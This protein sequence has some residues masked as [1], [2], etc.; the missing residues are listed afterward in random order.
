MG[1][2]VSA[3]KPANDVDLSQKLFIGTMLS[4]SWQMA[5]AVLVPT[6]LG[7]KLDAHFGTDPYITL[8]GLALAVVASVLIIR[9]A[10]KELNTYMMQD[11]A[12][13]PVETKATTP[14]HD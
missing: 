9:S 1:K 5:V 6:V 14:K 3:K 10:L 2:S 13:Q 11:N 12:A 7:Y 8:A 4:V